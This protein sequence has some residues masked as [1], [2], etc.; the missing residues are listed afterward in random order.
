[1]GYLILEIEESSSFRHGEH[2][3]RAKGSHKLEPEELHPLDKGSLI[4]ETWVA[5]SWRHEEPY[6]K[7]PGSLVFKTWKASS[8]RHGE[9]YSGDRKSI[10]L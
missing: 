8:R 7:D 1:M 9:P 4:L 2:H 6:S 5:R 10:I 3:P